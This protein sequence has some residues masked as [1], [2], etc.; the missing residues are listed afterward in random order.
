MSTTW[1]FDTIENKHSLCHGKDCMKMFCSSLRKHAT[2]V[3]NFERRKCY[4]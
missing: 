1:A 2:H 4:C 3:I